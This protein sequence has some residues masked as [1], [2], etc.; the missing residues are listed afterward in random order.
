MAFS[1]NHKNC[2][3]T[4]KLIMIVIVFG[5]F[6]FE[7]MDKYSSDSTFKLK[8]DYFCDLKILV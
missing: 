5:N 3:Y 8:K 6:K 7:L 1:W 4:T 2:K